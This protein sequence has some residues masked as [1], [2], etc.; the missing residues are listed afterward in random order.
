MAFTSNETDPVFKVENCI[1]FY[2]IYFVEN[3]F[4]STD[5]SIMKFNKERILLNKVDG[6]SLKAVKDN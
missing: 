3:H 6:T 4:G 2:G 5:I 1:K